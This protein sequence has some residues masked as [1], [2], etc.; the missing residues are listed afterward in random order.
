M[1]D[2]LSGLLN[3]ATGTPPWLLRQAKVTTNDYFCLSTFLDCSGLQIFALLPFPIQS[4]RLS[5][6]TYPSLCSTC[7]TYRTLF[8]A[9]FH[10]VLPIQTLHRKATISIGVAS[11]LSMCICSHTQLDCSQLLIIRD[12]Y[13]SMSKPQVLYLC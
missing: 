8:Y 7:V 13:L 4:F 6:I 2:Q 9:R 10:Q 1:P 12:W 5:L 11:I 3:H